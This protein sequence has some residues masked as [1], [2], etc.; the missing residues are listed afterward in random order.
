MGA[1]MISRFLTALL[2]VVAG[3][4]QPALSQVPS[5]ANLLTHFTCPAPACTTTCGG[6]SGPLTI[7]AKD[8][9]VFQFEKHPRRVWLLADGQVHILGDDDRCHFGGQTNISFINPPVRSISSVCAP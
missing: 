4:T 9:R 8:V 2:F 5:G 3:L 6:P 1:K 7:S